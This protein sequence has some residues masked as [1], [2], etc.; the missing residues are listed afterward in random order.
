M[1]RK[2]VLAAMAAAVPV[3]ALAAPAQAAV[4]R[5]GRVLA[6]TATPGPG[7]GQVTFSW[8]QDGSHTTAFLIETGLT[9][10]KA[11]DPKLPDH[12][13]N[14]KYFNVPAGRRSVTLSA[15]QVAS[16]GAGAGSGNHLY[17]RLRAVN[18][19]ASGTGVRDWPYLQSV[20]VR[21]LAAS[22]TGTALRVASFNVRTANATTDAR[23]WLQRAPLVAKTIVSRNPGVVALQELGPGRADGKKL[24]TAGSVRQTESLVNALRG[25]GGAKYRLVR[26]TPYGKPGVTEGTQGMRILY[27]TSRYSLASKCPDT[28]STGNN[29]SSCTFMLPIRSGD[30]A[31]DRRRAAYALLQDRATGK[32]FFVVS[33]HLDARHSSNL[34]T[35]RS[36]EALRGSQMK[37]V[38][39]HVNALNSAH[40]PVVLAGDLNSWQNNKG[41]YAAH[42]A[43]VAG[44]YYD[45]AAAATQV[46]VRYT[47]MNAFKRT[48]PSPGSSGWGAR[49]DVIAVK[50]IKGAQRFENVMKV[51]DANRPSDHNMIVADVRL[52]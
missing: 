1:I 40:L 17:Y 25:N 43:L 18:K 41:G 36:L 28:S 6:V 34:T 47:T 2:L 9:S 37:T 11:N 30:K 51:T 5:P 20:G 48:I 49:L 27:D 22:A 42:D 12:G 10:F 45:T 13:R 31:T 32:R 39:A 26:T 3:C 35:E 14:A 23:T 29:S 4:L 52:P 24:S 44:G 19:T 50:G 46:N 21:P 15:A 16:A 38:L 7:A 33:A 8:K